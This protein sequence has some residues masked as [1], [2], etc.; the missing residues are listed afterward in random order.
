ME[1]FLYME[2]TILLRVKVNTGIGNRETPIIII[3]IGNC[4]N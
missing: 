1:M 4:R 3:C 2:H